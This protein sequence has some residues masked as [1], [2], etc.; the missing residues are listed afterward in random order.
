MR[1]VLLGRMNTE[2]VNKSERF[3]R[4]KEKL[5]S[6]GITLEAVHYTQGAYDFVDVISTKDP[7]AALAFSVWYASRGFGSIT[8]MPAYTAEEFAQALEKL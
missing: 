2:W 1:Y 6:L 4:S 3:T 7:Q 5:E 8:S